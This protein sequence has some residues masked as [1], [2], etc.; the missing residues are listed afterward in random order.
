MIEFTCAERA[1]PPCQE[2]GRLPWLQ[3]EGFSARRCCF[4]VG[5]SQVSGLCLA[6]LAGVALSA[7]AVIG[8]LSFGCRQVHGWPGGPLR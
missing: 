5:D 2:M 3:S 1:G 6:G 7:E 4:Q 8:P